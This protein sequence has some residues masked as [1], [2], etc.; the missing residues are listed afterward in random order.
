MFVDEVSIEV[1]A[2]N[3]GNGMATFRREKFVPR[4]G[5][6]GGDGGHGGDVVLVVDPNLSTLLDFRF[7]HKYKAQRG[8]DGASKDM[9]GRKAEP[10]VLKVPPGTVVTDQDTGAPIADLNQPGEEFIVAHGGVGGRGNAHFATPVH[11]APQFAEQGEPGEFKR[12][13]LELK[14]LADVGLLGFPNVGKSTLI[15][16]LSAAR[17]KIANYPFTTLVP[18]LGVVGV[19]QEG[20][21]VMADIPGIIE[22]ASHGA[23]LGHQFLRHVERCRLLVHI[24]DVSG[25]S[26]REPLE[27]FDI[28]NRELALHSEKLAALPQIVALNKVD[29]AVDPEATDALEAALAERGIDVY[30]IS[31]VTRQGLE[32]LLYQIWT[33]LVALRNAAATEAASDRKVVI[34]ADTREDDRR[35]EVRAVDEHTYEVVGKGIERLVAMTDLENEQ[36]LRRLQRSFDKIGVNNRLKAMGAQDGDTVRI[37]DIEFDY[38][39]E[40]KPDPETIEEVRGGRRASHK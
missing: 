30:R 1:Q 34:T 36:A 31:A 9:F 26:G 10:L 29:V 23:G 8:G 17:P 18:N 25:M 32:A 3:G 19:G 24:L 33:R 15:S 7:K 2:G 5:P 4:G 37:R 21:F 38:E 35:W 20:S 12:L 39:D 27:D 6:N 40:D 13:T 22:G 28:L 11:Q 14:L 16:A